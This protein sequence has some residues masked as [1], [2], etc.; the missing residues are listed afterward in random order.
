MELGF[1]TIGNATLI[2][3]DNG[4]V[5]VTDPWTDGGAYFGSW[6]LSHEIPEAQRE[7]I[8]GCRFVWLSHGHPDHLSLESLEKLRDKTLL[9]PNHFGNRIRDDL[10]AQGFTVQVLVDRTWTQLSPR[11]RVMCLPDMNQD[12]VL[13]VDVGGRLL[14]NLND[15][16]DRGWG[17]FVRKLVSQYDESY[18]LA[19]S[20][21]GDA[22]M[23]NYFTEDGQRIAPYAA[24]KNPVGRT[25]ARQAEFYGARYFVPF[26]S[27][28]KYQ[29]ADS[30]WASEYTTTLDDY[31]RGFESQ[32]CALLP[33]FIQHDFIKDDTTLI[34]PK[35]RALTPVDPKEFGDDWSELLE[36]DEARALKAYFRSI[37]HL[38][39][40]LDF[41][42]FRVGGQDHVIE[43]HRRRFRRG[44]TFE[45]PRN[46]LMTA[47]RYQV[48]DDLLIGN[49]MKTTLHGE[50]GEGKLYPDF[51][52]YV[53]KYADN[54]KAR[55][56][57]ELKAYFADYRGRDMVGF[58]RARVEAHCVRPLQTQSAELL[59]TLLPAD[60]AAFR[61]AKETFWKVRRA[62]L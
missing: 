54:G 18:L 32:S 62:L 33:A 21:Y 51:S 58:L 38:G 23:I 60:S 55:T 17:R 15:A 39:S 1:E 9:V 10:R 49:F 24:A 25:I 28:H 37:E 42:R 59:R 20:G 16:G 36:V 41:L 13:L 34:R 3:H 61:T 2:C 44:I 35:E 43:F 40:A 47:V 52:P 22:D 29:R 14:V 45:A 12:A 46:S 48:F 56:R 19:L 26:S 30:V 53:A 6:T 5:L 50:F 27:M 4:P 31:A 8:Q 11:V 57:N 7:S